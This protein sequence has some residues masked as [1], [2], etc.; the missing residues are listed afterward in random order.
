MA[1]VTSESTIHIIEPYEFEKII[2]VET[3]LKL[4]R[5]NLHLPVYCSVLYIFLIFSFQQMMKNRTAFSLRVP[6]I[7]WNLTMALNSIIGSIRMFPGFVHIIRDFGLTF[8][9]CDSKYF[10]TIQPTV[11]WSLIFI[12]SRFVELGDTFFIVFRKRKL[13]FLHWYHHMMTLMSCWYFVSKPLAVAHWFGVMNNLVHS[14]MYSY[15]AVSALKFRPPRFVAMIITC[16]QL[17][18]MFIGS[19]VCCWALWKKWS[20]YSCEFPN[21]ATFIA[22]LVYLIY[23]IL[24]TRLFYYSYFFKAEKSLKKY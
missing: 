11:F 14:L 10:Q 7:V 20:G 17:L 4:L 16:L 5:N 15:F 6:L 12:I 13:I 24:F 18:Q 19:F 1:S 21:D 2:D 23:V 8:S 9:V 3:W 22:L